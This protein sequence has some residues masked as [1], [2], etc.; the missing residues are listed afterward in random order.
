LHCLDGEILRRLDDHG[1][2]TTDPRDNGR[3]LCVLGAPTGL[4]LLTAPTR[5]APQRPLATALRLPLVASGGIEVIGFDRPCPLTTALIGQGRLA[6]PPTP[7]I[8]ATA[9]APHLLGK[10]P[11]GP[12]QAQQKRGEHPMQQRAFAAIQ[13]RAREVIAGVLAGL[14]FPA[15]ALQSRLL[16]VRPPRTDVV[17]LT[18]GTLEWALL[19]P[20]RL[21][22]G[23]TR[24]GVAEGVER[25]HHRHGCASPLI[26]SPGK[27]RIGDAPLTMEVLRCDKA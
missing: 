23:L 9:L 25:R 19:P 7:A 6:Q 22:I 11:R 10:T 17:A 14:L 27:N 24:V 5:S 16:V 2:L 26:T 20:Q 18:A 13:Q 3:P 12:R 8:A 21:D 1:P 15:V 4:A